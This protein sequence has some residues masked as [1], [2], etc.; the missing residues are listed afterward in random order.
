MK[1]FLNKLKNLIVK[2]KNSFIAWIDSGNKTTA[3]FLSPYIIMFTIFIVVPVVLAILLSITYFN[4]IQK[5]EYT[6]LSNYIF[7]LTQDE[8]F[9]KQIIPN[10]LLFAVVVGPGGYILSFFLAWMLSQISPKPRTVLALIIY[11]PSLTAGVAMSVMWK[12]IFSGDKEGYLN[13]ILLNMNIISE[14]IQ[15]LQNPQYL[16]PIMII[17]SLWSSMGVGFLAILAGLLNVNKELYEAAYIDG[18]KNRFQEI[19]HITIPSIKNQMLFS[20]VMSIVGTFSAGAIGVQL[21][22]SNPTPQNSGQLVLN[23]IEDYGIMRYELGMAAALSVILLL[24]IYFF[25][26]FFQKIIGSND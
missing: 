19:I 11:S 10:T 26:K 18:M 14:P 13:A 25:S 22:G 5:P 17:V 2:M 12:V 9:M 8:V 3:I 16:M 21:S 15:W 24:I 23:H 7:L 6:G 1:Q 4:G 20:A